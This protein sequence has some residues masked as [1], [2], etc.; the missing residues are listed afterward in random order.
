M[1][2]KLVIRVAAIVVNNHCHTPRHRIKVAL[3]VFLGYSSPCGFYIL[4]NLA[5]CSS[6]WCTPSH[7]LASTDHTFSIG[8][9]LGEQAGHG[10]NSIKVEAVFVSKHNNVPFHCSCPPFIAQLT[11]QTPVVPSQEETKHWTLSACHHGKR[12]N[13]VGLGS[14][15]P[16]LPPVSSDDRSTPQL[17][18]F[19]QHV[20]RFL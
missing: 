1:R 12:H 2:I 11:A 5:Y 7:S 19:I 4:P 3:D 17:L 10:S 20:D 13:E 8:H 18:D 9:R 6:E 14:V 16:S 15:D